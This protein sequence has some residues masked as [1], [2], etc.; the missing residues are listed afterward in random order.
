M[1]VFSGTDR[2]DLTTFTV[3]PGTGAGAFT[4]APNPLPGV[5]G[6]E[7]TY[8]ASWSGLAAAS[9]YL[10]LVRY[11]DSGFSTVVAVEN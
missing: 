6:V 7:A 4:V 8:T 10:G 5:Q 1:S 2:Y 9:D 11:G 3:A